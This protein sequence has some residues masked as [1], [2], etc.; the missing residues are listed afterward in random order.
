MFQTHLPVFVLLAVTA[1]A[2]NKASSSGPVAGL[3]PLN[4]NPGLSG[5]LLN[6]TSPK[7]GEKWGTQQDA[8]A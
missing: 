1:H 4:P 3:T 6:P 8:V 2:Q 5:S 7:P